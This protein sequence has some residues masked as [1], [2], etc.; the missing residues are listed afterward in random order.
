MDIA[1][2]ISEAL[3]EDIGSGDVTTLAMVPEE[4][5]A[6]AQIEVQAECVLCG[7]DIARRVFAAV[8]GTLSFLCRHADGDALDCGAAIAIIDGKARSLLAAERTALNFLQH[9]SGIAT[10][11]SRFVSHIAGTNAKILDTRKT[12]PGWRELEKY[13]VATGG[14]VNHRRGLFDRY[15]VKSNHIDMHESLADALELLAASRNRKLMLE[16]E[17]RDIEEAKEAAEFGVDVIMLDNFPLP[18]VRKAVLAIS[19]RAKVEVSGGITLENVRSYAEAG[20]D[21]IAVGAITHSAPAAVIHM[22][23]R[24]I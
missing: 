15:L 5:K 3:A 17:A 10:L 7:V 22:T 8:D 11:T 20:V 23:I 21:Y 9:L 13:A 16:V 2:L 1:T 14:G 18:D 19:G 24:P 6:R 12:I 4:L